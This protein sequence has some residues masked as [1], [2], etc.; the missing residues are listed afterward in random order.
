MEGYVNKGRRQDVTER[1]DRKQAVKDRRS[2]L[3]MVR[4][5]AAV[6]L[7]RKKGEK[8]AFETIV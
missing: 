8:I 3:V 1:V 4:K 6:A 7:G 2:F 5:A